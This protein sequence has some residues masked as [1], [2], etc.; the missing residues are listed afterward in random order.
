[1]LY[2]SP[3]TNFKVTCNPSPLASVAQTVVQPGDTVPAGASPPGQARGAPRGHDRPSHA[4]ALLLACN[5]L[6]APLACI[7]VTMQTAPACWLTLGTLCC[8]K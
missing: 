6:P 4:D 8:Q 1:M 3:P 7:N 2:S 5:S